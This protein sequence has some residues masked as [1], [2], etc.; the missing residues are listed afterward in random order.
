ML[1]VLLISL[2]VVLRIVPHP[3]NF[4]PVGAAAVFAGRTLKPWMAGSL[5]VVSMFFGDLVLSR[6]HGY[7]LVSWVTPFVYGGFLV[8]ALFGRLLRQKKGGALGA[9][10]L[11]ALSF[12]AISNF[13]VWVAGTMY[14]HTLGGLGACYIAAIP[15]LGGTLIGDV[16]WTAILS[17]V[18]RPAA[19]RL[20]AHRFWVPVPAEELAPI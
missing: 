16:V 13:G 4:A 17:V 11:G 6:I 2:C 5:V 19:A 8:Q 18:Y 10:V 14:P 3:P 9:A 12:F 1:P 7:A 15:F 20:D